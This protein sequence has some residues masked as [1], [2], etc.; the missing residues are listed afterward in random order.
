MGVK[1]KF[2]DEVFPRITILGRNVGVTNAM[3][4]YALEKFSKIERIDAQIMDLF[5]TMDIQKLDNVVDVLMKFS[6]FIVKV[7]GHSTDMYASIDKAFER[8]QA[9][10]RK[11]KD[12]IQDHQA[13]DISSVDMMVNVIRRPYNELE[14]INDDIEEENEK[15]EEEILRLHEIVEVTS[16]HLKPLT[17]EEAVMKMELSEDLFLIYRSEEDRKIK[18]IYRRPDGNYGVIS[19]E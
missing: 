17:A 10:I 8:L 1:E 18:V 11:W 12:R 13:K 15:E 19:P 4:E 5:V 9:K 14:D 6:H 2:A 16:F 7:R 3:K